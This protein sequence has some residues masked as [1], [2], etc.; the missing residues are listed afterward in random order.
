MHAR[1]LVLAAVTS[2]ITA[3]CGKVVL[4]GTRSTTTLLAASGE[5]PRPAGQ[6][7]APF[8]GPF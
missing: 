7:A 4:A 5:K 3:P 6:V 2:H 8:S 1:V